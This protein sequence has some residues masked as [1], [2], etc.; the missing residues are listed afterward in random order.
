MISKQDIVGNKQDIAGNTEKLTNIWIQILAKIDKP[1][2]EKLSLRNLGMVTSIIRYA[3][4]KFFDVE[5][6]NEDKPFL[7]S[8]NYQLAQENISTIGKCIIDLLI[9]NLLRNLP[10]IPPNNILY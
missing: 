10:D 8:G 6:A 4:E 7:Y 9:K 3:N 5:L 2:V 1:M